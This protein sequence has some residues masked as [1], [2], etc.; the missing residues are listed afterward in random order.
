MCRVY[1]ETDWGWWV[2][3]Y[4]L[5]SHAVESNPFF[6]SFSFADHLVQVHPHTNQ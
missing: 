6:L 1:V 2:E 5:D 4:R 3:L